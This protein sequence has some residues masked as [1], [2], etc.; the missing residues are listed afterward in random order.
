MWKVFLISFGFVAFI[1]AIL[2]ATT[3]IFYRNKL[4]EELSHYERNVIYGRAT[5]GN[6]I[7]L[8]FGNLLSSFV[9][10]PVYILAG[11]ITLITWLFS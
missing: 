7:A 3:T 10:P 11:L 4:T 8:F 2:A 5:I 1:Y 6:R 9:A